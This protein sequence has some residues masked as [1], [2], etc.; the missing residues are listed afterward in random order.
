MGWRSVQS[1]LPWL[2]RARQWAVLPWQVGPS[3]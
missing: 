2:T 1:L 3:E